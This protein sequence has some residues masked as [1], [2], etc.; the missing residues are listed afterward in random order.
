MCTL[1]ATGG[2]SGGWLGPCKQQKWSFELSSWPLYSALVGIWRVNR[3]MGSHSFFLSH[4]FL[5]WKTRP[6]TDKFILG[7]FLSQWYITVKEVSS[8]LLLRSSFADI[9]QLW[10][11]SISFLVI[12][13]PILS[14]VCVVL[15]PRLLKKTKQ[16]SLQDSCQ[17][18]GEQPRQHKILLLCK[19]TR[20][21]K[22]SASG[23][24]YCSRSCFGA[25]L[26]RNMRSQWEWSGN[27][28]CFKK[29]KQE[30]EEGCVREREDIIPTMIKMCLAIEF[31]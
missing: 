3:Y 28:E 11:K 8:L 24:C 1:E 29:D 15:D 13:G 22:D 25:M 30:L 23:D 6:I 20:K 17:R 9:W 12:C 31:L 4:A 18:Q 26:S 2:S 27:T 10:G 21:C 14:A 5:Y 16:N 19:F 7:I